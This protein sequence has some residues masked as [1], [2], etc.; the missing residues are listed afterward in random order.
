MEVGYT[1]NFMRR[2][3]IVRKDLHMGAG[4]LAAQVAH[5]AEAY[6]TNMLRQH[7][8]GQVVA[9][10]STNSQTPNSYVIDNMHLDCDIYEDYVC[11]RF[12]KTV[13]QA[14]NKNHL[15]KAGEIAKELGLVEGRDY[16]FIYD[17]CFTDLTPEEDDGTC[18]TCF[19]TAPLDDK[20]AH[21]ISKKYHL[22]VDE[23][24]S[25]ENEP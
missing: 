8:V 4:K 25:G 11:G 20:T 13:C 3:F 2:L 19:W 16:G 24:G 14:R 12:V 5:C 17:A 9:V 21:K 1:N 18:L 10:K 6:W 22:Y 7:A 15:L 23:R